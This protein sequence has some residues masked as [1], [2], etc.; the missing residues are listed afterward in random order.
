M[1]AFKLDENVSPRCRAPLADA[2]CDVSTVGEQRLR[3]ADDAAVADA[4]RRERRCLITADQDFAQILDFPPPDYAGIVVLRHPRP[5]L[6][7]MVALVRQV[8]AA[9]SEES[10]VGR[11]WIVEPG[12]I[13]IHENDDLER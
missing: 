2:G 13:R 9:L 11:L 8:A 12:R 4:C 7:G 5:T 3:G 10:P 1:I 6:P